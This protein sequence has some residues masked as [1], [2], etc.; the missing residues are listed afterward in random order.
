MQ[1]TLSIPLPR[2]WP[3]PKF[4]LA[5][6]V[7]VKDFGAVGFGTIT[8]VKYEVP[9]RGSDLALGWWYEIDLD[10]THPEWEPHY[11]HCASESQLIEMQQ[12]PIGYREKPLSTL[13]I[14]SFC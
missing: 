9:R 3:M 14:R 6:R 10:E 13:E 11:A 7:K 12:L 2:R 5:Q 4:K 1:S 8:G